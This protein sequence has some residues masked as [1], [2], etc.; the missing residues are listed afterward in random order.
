MQEIKKSNRNKLIAMTAK[1]LTT[2]LCYDDHRTFTEDVRKRFSDGAQYE[3]LS[4]HAKQDFLNQCNM[5]SDNSSCKVAIIGV[6]DAKEQ[7][8][9]IDEM[10]MEI[11]RIDQSTGLI[12]LVPGDKMEDL[13]KVVRFNVDAYIPRNS[14]T[15]LRLHN[16]VKKIISEHSIAIFKKRR[17]FSLWFLFGF[18]ILSAIAVLVAYIR[19]PGY[20]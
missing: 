17:N 18:L 19:F 1:L 6:P 7:F 12:L 9:I 16:A 8:Q 13:K 4:F 3:V 20:F 10:T 11:K 2:L 15:I 5:E 14:N